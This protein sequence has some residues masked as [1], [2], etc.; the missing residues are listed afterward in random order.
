MVLMMV[1][2]AVVVISG[3]S[4]AMQVVDAVKIF[5]VSRGSRGVVLEVM[6]V[7]AAVTNFARKTPAT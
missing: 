3:V 7:T 1:A 4:I 2:A 5:S 6:M